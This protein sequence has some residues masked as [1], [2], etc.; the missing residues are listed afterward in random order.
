MFFFW[1]SSYVVV[2]IQFGSILGSYSSAVLRVRILRICCWSS[3]VKCV[4]LFAV[5]L[6]CRAACCTISRSRWS[7]GRGEA[8]RGAAAARVEIIRQ[9]R[10]TD[11]TLLPV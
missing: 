2:S 6:T 7:L 3:T 5:R 1:L 11:R 8:L 4:H 9:R 10:S